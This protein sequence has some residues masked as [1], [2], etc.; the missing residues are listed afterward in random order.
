MNANKLLLA[1]T[2]SIY[3]TLQLNNLGVART[4]KLPRENLLADTNHH[5]HSHGEHSHGS[6][7]I[8]PG[9]PIPSVNLIVHEDPMRGWNIEV[10]V[11]NFRFSPER[12][13]REHKPGEGHAHLYINGEKITR[14][15]GDWYYI[16]NL[17]PGRN[18]IKVT[19]NSNNHSDFLHNGQ[20]I[21]DTAIIEVSP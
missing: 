21:G 13:S 12:A 2:A 17:Q 7:E 15:Y 1:A 19:L 16:G 8:P 4:N 10:R 11:S 9:Q 5:H 6:M 3:F 18:E 14:L 20:I